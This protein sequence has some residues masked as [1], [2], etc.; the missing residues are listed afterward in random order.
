MKNH[1]AV[2]LVLIVKI[3]IVYG[4]SDSTWINNWEK[5]LITDSYAG[6]SNFNNNYQILKENLSLTT[7]NRPDSIIKQINHNVIDSL[8]YSFENSN[9]LNNDPLVMFN[10]DSTWLIQNAEKLWTDYSSKQKESPEINSIAINT[11]KDYSK[12]KRSIWSLQGSHWTDDY[13]LVSVMIVKGVDTLTIS[14]LGQYPFMLPWYV[15][16]KTIYNAQI[17]KLIVQLLPDHQESNKARLQGERLNYTLIDRIYESDLCDTIAYI[18]AKNRYKKQFRYLEK[19]FQIKH[20]ELSTMSSIEWG[21][22]LGRLAL[23]ILLSDTT[24]SNQIQFSTIFSRHNLIHSPKSIIRNKDKLIMRL[25][26]N[27][28][29]KYTLDCEKCLGEIHWVQSKSLSREA[30]RNFLSD[31]KDI[32]GNRREFRG[33]FRNA[34]FYELTEDKDSK[35]SFSQWIFLNDG[36]IILWQLQGDYLMNLSDCL[37]KYQ[38]YVCRTITLR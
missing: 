8:F 14:S 2:V 32:G 11:L 6:W 4:Q 23:E 12:I 25:S 38:G 15:N 21:H 31:L 37:T 28:I 36:R 30:K 5:I 22:F 16:E 10:L 20:A 27:P 17:S 19:D 24:I 3:T 34:I 13:P 35:R 7:E 26:N 1:L 18:K 9:R 29:Y 33:K